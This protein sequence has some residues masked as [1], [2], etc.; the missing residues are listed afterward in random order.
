MIPLP[1][2][3]HLTF[4]HIYPRLSYLIS[5]G[6]RDINEEMCGKQRL[7]KRSGCFGIFCI[8]HHVKPMVAR[9]MLKG[10]WPSHICFPADTEPTTRHMSEATLDL[11]PPL[12]QPRA[13]E[14]LNGLTEWFTPLPL[15]GVCYS[16]K[17]DTSSNPTVCITHLSNDLDGKP[18]CWWPDGKN[19]PPIET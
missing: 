15:G 17:T 12:S 3:T 13:E 1:L 6:Q 14:L 2:C 7:G 16:A 9:Q 8:H 10:T 4:S 11:T 5:F 18:W 19:F